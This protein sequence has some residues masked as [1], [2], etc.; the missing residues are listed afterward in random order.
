ML[1]FNFIKF[2]LVKTEFCLAGGVWDNNKRIWPY[3]R[4]DANIAAYGCTENPPEGGDVQHLFVNTWPVKC[5]CSD[6]EDSRVPLVC[7]QN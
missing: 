7:Q 4:F 2:S 6:V 5:I 1:S 3:R